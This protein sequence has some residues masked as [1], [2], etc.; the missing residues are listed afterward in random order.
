MGPRRPW[1]FVTGTMIGKHKQ[2]Q[3]LWL[4]NDNNSSSLRINEAIFQS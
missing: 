1:N 2:A 4:V 3:I